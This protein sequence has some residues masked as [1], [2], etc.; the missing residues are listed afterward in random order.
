MKRDGRPATLAG[1]MG[2]FLIVH[3]GEPAAVRDLAARGAR[4]LDALGL[5]PAAMVFQGGATAVVRCPRRGAPAERES[6][7]SADGWAVAAGCWLAGGRDDASALARLGAS[8]RS[9][10]AAWRAA[11]APLD[12]FFAL[13]AGDPAGRELAAATDRTGTLHLYRAAAGS[14]EL[15]STSSLLLA[16]LAGAGFDPVAVHEFLGTGSVFESRSLHAGVE[17]LPPAVLLRWRDGRL[18]A[19]ERWW[20]L[21]PLLWGGAEARAHPGDVPALAGALTAALDALLAAHPAAVLDLTGGFDSRAV[22]GA[23][24][25]T[26][27]PF[28]TV[29]VGADDDGDVVAAGAIAR[30]FGLSHTHLV[31]GRDYGAR[32]LPDLRAALALCDGEADVVEYAGIAQIQRR[33]A[34]SA[35]AAGAGGGATINGS[36]GELCRGYWWDLLPSLDAPGPAFDARRAALGRFATDDWADRMLAGAGDAAGG[37]A[38]LADH[39]T[40]V[41]ERAV[42]DLRDLPAVALA[43]VIY[44]TLRMQ[45]W[46]GRLVSAT[47]RL[48]PCV[49]PFMFEGPMRAALSAPPE[50]RRRDRMMRALIEHLNPALALLP[51][52]DGSPALPLRAGTLHRFGPHAVALGGKAWGRVRRKLGGAAR[53][54]APSGGAGEAL[55]RLVSAPDVAVLLEPGAMR[56]RELYDGQALAAFVAAAR[57]PGFDQPRRWGR[58]LT[59]EL[60][61]QALQR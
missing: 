7:P 18:V 15:L 29:V 49:S 61:A 14:C 36:S 52:A 3:G 44:L 2:P 33:M 56:T 4:R 45:R 9:G 19:R 31:P 59:L 55:A 50:R 41:V 16:G 48:W 46:A 5:G 34:E 37:G 60:V 26:G 20:E 25:A 11:A 32:G 6:A 35:G 38:T 21:R 12:G 57:A 13:A 43:D 10:T 22:L 40:G 8:L 23:A 54:G 1:D 30:A 27:R 58:V 39:F 42:A 28:R 47:D 51:M 53:S 24:L 17:K